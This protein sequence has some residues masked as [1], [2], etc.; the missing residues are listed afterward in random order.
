MDMLQC[1]SY[2]NAA[3]IQMLWMGSCRLLTMH[4]E[5][6]HQ[7]P[8]FSL[9]FPQREGNEIYFYEADLICLPSNSSIWVAI[10]ISKKNC[11]HSL[12][13]KTKSTR[14]Q[15]FFVYLFL[16]PS[17]YQNAAFLNKNKMI[18]RQI[19]WSHQ[20]LNVAFSQHDR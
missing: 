14:N 11:N 15:N 19:F 1:I 10:A 18:F 17:K 3:W 8:Q 13:T 2:V 9:A 20:R 12:F 6:D 5:A 4:W 16:F 7:S